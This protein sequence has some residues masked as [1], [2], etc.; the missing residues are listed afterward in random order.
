MDAYFYFCERFLLSLMLF[1]KSETLLAA[2]EKKL[3]NVK[4]IQFSNICVP[5]L[6]VISCASKQSNME[7]NRNLPVKVDILTKQ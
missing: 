4:M 1:K 3:K 5:K 6:P 7:H 2:T